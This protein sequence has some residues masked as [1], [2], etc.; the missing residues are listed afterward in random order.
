MSRYPVIAEATNARALQD[1]AFA[2][3]TNPDWIE[4][5]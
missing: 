1:E 4:V 5:G 2:L 3:I